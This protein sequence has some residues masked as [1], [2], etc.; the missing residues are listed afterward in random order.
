MAQ[1]GSPDPGL[2]SHTEDDYVS[3]EDEDFDPTNGANEAKEDLS[4]ESDDEAIASTIKACRVGSPKRGDNNGH[5]EDLGFENSGDEA[6]IRKGR[7]RRR[8]HG[9][10]EEDESGGEGGFVKTRTMR[11]AE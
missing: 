6:T 8:K 9:E 5:V 3:S 7:K 11:A 1:S 10:G 4:S 2:T